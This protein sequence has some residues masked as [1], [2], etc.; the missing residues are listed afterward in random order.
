[1]ARRLPRQGIPLTTL[2]A[3][4]EVSTWSRGKASY[5]AYRILTQYERWKP[6]LESRSPYPTNSKSSPLCSKSGDQRQRG[7][8][9]LADPLPPGASTAG[10]FRPRGSY[11]RARELRGGDELPGRAPAPGPRP[12]QR[13]LQETPIAGNRLPT[14]H[15][16]GTV[17]SF[18]SA[19]LGGELSS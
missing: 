1:M 2:L 6:W 5:D 15:E 4:S 9:G 7:G 12:G 17:A 19:R 8:P 10:A 16:P 11:R 3:C 18:P 13:L 14:G